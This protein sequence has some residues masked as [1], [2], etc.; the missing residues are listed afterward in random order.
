MSG[1]VA[2]PIAAPA[3][4]ADA[5][6]GDGW[7]P[8]LSIAH[9]RESARIATTVT[10]TRIRDALVA[11]AIGTADA[12]AGWRALQGDAQ[13]LTDVDSPQFGG[14]KRCMTLWRR[15]VYAFAA[16]DLAETH[17][18]ISA[19]DQ[20]RKLNQERATTADD[21]RRSATVAIRDLLGKT[22]SRAALL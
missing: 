12:L 21:H 14:E 5:I 20:G 9:F 15:A 1:F 6:T 7:W 2:A 22:R 16:A 13:S 11:A 10:D 18:D 4:I 8:A 3:P 19:T 17:N